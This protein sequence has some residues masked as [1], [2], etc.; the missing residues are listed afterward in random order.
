MTDALASSHPTI[1]SAVDSMSVR[2]PTSVVPTMPV[3]RRRAWQN[4]RSSDEQRVLRCVG[5][6]IKDARG[7]RRW[8]QRDLAARSGIDPSH[9][10]VLEVGADNVTVLTLAALARAFRCSVAT[11]VR[12]A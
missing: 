3:S 11:L 6:A 10:A 12:G 8:T 9:I 5:Q 7:R 2:A 4:R 1:A